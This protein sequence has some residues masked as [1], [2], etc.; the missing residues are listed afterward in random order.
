MQANDVRI[1]NWVRQRES[2][3]YIQIEQYLLCN[4]ELCHYQPIAITEEWL[5]KFG[6]YKSMSWTYA[7]ELKGNLKLVYYLGEKGWSIGFKSY[8]DFSNL[9]YVHQLQNL[10][11]VLCGEELKMEGDK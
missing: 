2:D 10:Y 3:T 8:S 5:L 11:W 9:K 7:I 6:F 4:E 1:G